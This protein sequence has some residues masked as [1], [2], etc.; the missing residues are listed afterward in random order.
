MW[1][2][3]EA[4]FQ[5]GVSLGSFPGSRYTGYGSYKRVLPWVGWDSDEAFS[6]GEDLIGLDLWHIN[7]DR[8][9][10]GAISWDDYPNTNGATVRWTPDAER[11]YLQRYHSIE[12]NLYKNRRRDGSLSET[13]S[14]RSNAEDSRYTFEVEYTD[15]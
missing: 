11:W 8:P 4:D 10:D 3:I 2:K 9:L 15:F 13:R 5:P 7:L 12:R 6:A 1:T 14:N